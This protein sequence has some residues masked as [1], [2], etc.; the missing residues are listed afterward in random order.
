[1]AIIII[2]GLT[3]INAQQ[4]V[5]YHTYIFIRDNSMVGSSGIH[6]AT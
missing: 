2:M 5:Q 3:I 6:S 4:L 1:M